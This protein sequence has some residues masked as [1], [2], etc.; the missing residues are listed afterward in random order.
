MTPATFT[1]VTREKPPPRGRG[2]VLEMNRVISKSVQR[3]NSEVK[4][5]V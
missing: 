2:P 3:I 1:L 5:N 4:F